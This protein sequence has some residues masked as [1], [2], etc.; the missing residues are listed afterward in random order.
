MKQKGKYMKILISILFLLSIV[1]S[2]DIKTIELN[3]GDKLNDSN[4]EENIH[5]GVKLRYG[6]TYYFHNVLNAGSL[7]LF[8]NKTHVEFITNLY[9]GDEKPVFG[10]T[11]KFIDKKYQVNPYTSEKYY[12]S[13][14]F[15]INH[16]PQVRK[17]D[18]LII[19]YTT[20]Y[21]MWLGK[22]KIW[23]KKRQIDLIPYEITWCGDGVVDKY[24]DKATATNINE[25]CDPKDKQKVNW[26]SLGCSSE[27]VKLK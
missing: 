4:I 9:S 16:K 14:A 2:E 23:V 5:K 27:C 3:N 25:E 15:T 20:N 10:C 22:P 19:K 13:R 26:G 7:Y 18:N 11:K 12:A 24:F 21:S 17:Y 6:K 1:N 8:V